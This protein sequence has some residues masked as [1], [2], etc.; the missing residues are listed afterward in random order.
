MNSFLTTAAG[1]SF[2][3][4]VCIY[5]AYALLGSWLHVRRTSEDATIDTG[6]KHA[7]QAQSTASVHT[8]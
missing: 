6:E 3:L 2:T 8:A 7:A 1:L 5:V 4:F